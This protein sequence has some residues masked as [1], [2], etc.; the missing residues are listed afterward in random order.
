MISSYAMIL[1]CLVEDSR[2]PEMT[3]LRALLC[4]AETLSKQA[5]EVGLNQT[6]TIC[7]VRRCFVSSR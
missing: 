7:T 6:N 4:H 3:R 5:F 2:R 1:L